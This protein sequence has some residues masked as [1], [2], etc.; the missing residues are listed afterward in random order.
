MNILKAYIYSKGNESKMTSYIEWEK[1]I[2]YTSDK[3]LIFRSY[4][5]NS[6]ALKNKPNNLIKNGQRTLMGTFQ[7][8]HT[9]I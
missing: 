5:K 6:S 1:I 4:K 8:R 3:G 7:R 2:N 9:N